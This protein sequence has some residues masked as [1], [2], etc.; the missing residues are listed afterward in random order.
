[1]AVAGNVA[2]QARAQRYALPKRPAALSRFGLDH[3]F[4]RRIVQHADAGVIVGH[5]RYAAETPFGAQR[6]DAEFFHLPHVIVA[7]QHWLPRS[8]DVFGDVVS[9]RTCALRQPRAIDDLDIELNFVA[10]GIQLR[11]V[12]VF[13]VEETPQ[14]LP[15]FSRQILFVQRGAERAA[16]LVHYVKL[17]RSPRSLLNQVTA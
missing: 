5:Q 4:A 9:G 16:D 12:E 10:Q 11:D 2:D 13:H 6:L 14:L 7:D 15:N 17:F 8:N 1:M 3:H